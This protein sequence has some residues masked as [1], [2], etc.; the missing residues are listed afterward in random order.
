MQESEGLDPLGVIARA[1]RLLAVCAFIGAIV[2]VGGVSQLA[3][4]YTSS[5]RLKIIVDTT[6]NEDP[7]RQVSTQLGLVTSDDVVNQVATL[8]HTSAFEVR[9]H[10]TATAD[11]TADLIT[12]SA[13]ASSSAAAQQLAQTVTTTFVDVSRS[14]GLAAKQAQLNAQNQV[15]A[16]LKQQLTTL[17]TGSAT[18]PGAQQAYADAVQQQQTLSGE[19][20]TFTSPASVV[21][22]ADTPSAPSGLGTKKA[23]VLGLMLG[24]IAGGVIAFVRAGRA[25]SGGPMGKLVAATGVPVIASLPTLTDLSGSDRRPSEAALDGGRAAAAALSPAGNRTVLI[26]GTGGPDQRPLVA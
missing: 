14:Q 2:V 23:G 21:T 9:R 15:V 11:T 1:W 10:V 22:N 26:T 16:S 5:A 24:L 4:S 6:G 12:I 8:L 19:V 3:K 20:S 18:L 7:A 25:A 17:S 13:K